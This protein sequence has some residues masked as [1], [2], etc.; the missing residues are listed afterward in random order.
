[1][2]GLGIGLFGAFIA[3]SSFFIAVAQFRQAIK[4]GEEQ[5]QSLD[6]SRKQLEAVVD[7]LTNQQEVLIKGLETSKSL[8][9]LQKEQQEVLT[10]SLEVSRALLTLQK[11]E[12][13]RVQELANRKPKV[14]I[15]IGDHTPDKGMIETVLT[16]GQDNKGQL[17]IAIKNIGSAILL[18]PV[19]MVVASR[20]DISIR[21]DG[22]PLNSKKPS[23]TQVSAPRLLDFL[24]YA[25]SA[26]LYDSSI[27]VTVPPSVSDFHID[28]TVT[29]ENLEPR[30]NA[31]MHVVVK[32]D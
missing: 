10:R 18:K 17:P 7:S 8:F 30:F 3:I 31:L 11:E 13:Q 28:Y 6:S 26:S 14:Q 27:Q 16:V 29:G 9:A 2:I 19:L 5:R 25:T 20:Q 22:V 32:R 15:L 23:Q 4:D 1:M 12:R 21:F 24:P